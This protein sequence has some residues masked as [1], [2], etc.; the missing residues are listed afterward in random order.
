MI[1][2]F[3][4]EE[5]SHFDFD[6]TGGCSAQMY[7]EDVK[8]NKPTDYDIDCLTDGVTYDNFRC[9]ECQEKF[10]DNEEEAIKFLKGENGK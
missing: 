10:F 4:K 5:I 9:P 8:A 7:E 3:C 6:V 2:K 1:C